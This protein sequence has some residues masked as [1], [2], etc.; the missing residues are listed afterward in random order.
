MTTEEKKPEIR[1]RAKSKYLHIVLSPKTIPSI[2]P[3]KDYLEKKALNY[4]IAVEYGITGGNPHIDCFCEFPKEKRPDNFKQN[5]LKKTCYPDKFT[6]LEWRNI[7]VTIN[8]ID[9]DP[10]YGYGYTMKE[11]PEKYFT[12]LTEDYLR[13]CVEYFKE[14][15]A[16]VNKIKADIAKQSKGQKLITLD[17]VF[18]DLVK[19]IE[20]TDPEFCSA[21]EFPKFDNFTDDG[22]RER[23]YSYIFYNF[24]IHLPY[25]IPHSLYSKIN[26]QCMVFHAYSE[27]HRL[28]LSKVKR[29][30]P[31]DCPKPKP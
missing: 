5:V 2:E 28:R 27:I 6:D 23:K 9:E 30:S 29:A 21:F 26:Q 24:Y 10:R 3:L 7:K 20:A 14:N 31:L 8:Y 13:D 17:R 25:P 16:R 22:G 12:S 11:T 1:K 19:W 15:E 18:S 4:C